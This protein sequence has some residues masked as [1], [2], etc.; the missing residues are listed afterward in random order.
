MICPSC[1][2]AVACGQPCCKEKNGK[3]AM[4]I[5][6]INDEEDWNESCPHCGLTESVHWWMDE[7]YKQYYTEDTQNV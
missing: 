5:G 7:E 3:D 4:I 1:K 2:Q 6:D